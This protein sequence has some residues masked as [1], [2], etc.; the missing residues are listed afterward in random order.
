MKKHNRKPPVMEEQEKTILKLDQD[1]LRAKVALADKLLEI[2]QLEQQFASVQQQYVQAVVAYGQ[3]QGIDFE[4]KTQ[5]W[6]F[7]GNSLKFMRRE[8]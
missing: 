5:A 3:A 4:D 6:H 7:D 8:D 1:M 2:R